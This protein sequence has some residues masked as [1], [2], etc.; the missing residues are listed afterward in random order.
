MET[1]DID[2][3]NSIYRTASMGSES[4]SQILPEVTAAPLRSELSEQ[5]KCYHNDKN[6]IVSEMR[7]AGISPSPLPAVKKLMSK[8]GTAVELAG[9][10][11]SR[12]IAEMMIQGSNMGIIGLNKA[13]NSDRNAPAPVV[14]QAQ[15]MLDSEQKY[16]DRLKKYL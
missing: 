12:H 9:D 1:Q 11:G 4:I 6:K 7:K 8:V 3:Y 16:I 2:L 10:S 15:D 5:L 14:R 13:L